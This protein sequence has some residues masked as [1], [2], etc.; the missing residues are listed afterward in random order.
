MRMLN[1][2]WYLSAVV[3]SHCETTPTSWLSRARCSSL[4]WGS[5]ISCDPS[6]ASSLAAALLHYDT[7]S[8]Q[9]ASQTTLAP[10]KISHLPSLSESTV[11]D[12]VCECEI[13]SSKEEVLW[14][15]LQLHTQRLLVSLL[16]HYMSTQSASDA[17]C[18]S[19][20]WS[21]VDFE[22]HPNQSMRFRR[23]MCCAAFLHGFA[24]DAEKHFVRQCC[25]FK[26]MLE[27]FSVSTPQSSET[28]KYR[29][30]KG[31]AFI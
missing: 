3:P 16:S 6:Q 7:D 26:G 12:Y 17:F 11:V 4:T 30:R 27:W 29:L 21:L 22:S 24:P 28:C 1:R 2:A 25:I 5:L 14:N 8:N 20:L 13:E 15:W 23:W 18:E 31:K 19:S 9:T 10:F